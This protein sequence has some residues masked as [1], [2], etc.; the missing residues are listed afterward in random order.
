LDKVKFRQIDDPSATSDLAHVTAKYNMGL[1]AK[2]LLPHTFQNDW[3][4]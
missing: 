4:W 2:F 1:L 3:C